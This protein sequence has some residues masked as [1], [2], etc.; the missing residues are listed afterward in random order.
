MQVLGWKTWSEEIISKTYI[1]KVNL[2]LYQTVEAHT[3][4]RRR[5]YHIF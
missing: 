1:Y 2:S 3:F 5:G 4:V